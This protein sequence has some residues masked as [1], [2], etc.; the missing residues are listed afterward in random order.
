MGNTAASLL[1][2]AAYIVEHN[3]GQKEYCNPSNGTTCAAGAIRAA[4]AGL[5]RYPT[6]W[7]TAWRVETWSPD[8]ARREALEALTNEIELAGWMIGV[9][10]WNDQDWQDATTVAETMRAAAR[11]WEAE[12]LPAAVRS[13]LDLAGGPTAT[14]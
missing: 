12:N 7:H 13:E 9:E 4:D 5:F 11:R 3:W 6:A 14:G 1:Y 8:Q 2:G 10:S